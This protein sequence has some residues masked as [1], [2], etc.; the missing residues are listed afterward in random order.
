MQQSTLLKTIRWFLYALVGATPLVFFRYSLFP[1]GVPKIVFFEVFTELIVGGWIALLI[2]DWPNKRYLPRR[3]PLFW[4]IVCFTLL[5]LISAFHGPDLFRSFWSTLD[6]AFGIFG[7]L[8]VLA[9]MLIVPTLREGVPW[10]RLLTVSFVASVLTSL[11]VV[12]SKWGLQGFFL[13]QSIPRP[14]GTFGN[15]SFVGAYLLFNVFLGA[16]LWREARASARRIWIGVGVLVVTFGIL[17]TQ[18][19]GIILGL[20]GGAFVLLFWLGIESRGPARRTVLALVVIGV[21]VASLFVAT[22]KNSVWQKV[23]GLSRVATISRSQSDVQDRLLAWRAGWEGF[24]D[25]PLLGWGWENG[26][27]PFNTHYD[28]KLLVTSFEGTYFDKPHNVFLEQLETGGI[29]GFVSYL[30]LFVMWGYEL[31]RSRRGKF[32]S[33]VPF[34]GAGMVAYLL[35]NTIS[36]D[37]IGTYLMLA[38]FFAFVEH[39]YEEAVPRVSE[40]S[41]ADAHVSGAKQWASGV[42]LALTLCLALF[43][44]IPILTMSYNYYWG[45]N[46]FLNGLLESSSVSWQAALGAHTP[47]QDAVRKDYGSTLQQAFQQGLVYPHL[48]ALQAKAATEGEIAVSRH[49]DDYIYRISLADLYVTFTPFGQ[50]DYLT[51]AKDQIAAAMRLSPLRQQPYYVLARERI[52][53]HDNQGAV[54][55]LKKAIA[56]NPESGDPHFTYGL[57]A[58]SLG[59]AATGR[60]EVMTAAALG[61]TPVN[62]KEALALGGFKRD[63][64]HDYAE[65]VRYFEAAYD[66]AAFKGSKTQMIQA[67]IEA[68][69]L[70]ADKLG[71]YDEAESR[72]RQALL[73][74][75][76]NKINDQIP[77]VRL[78]LAVTCYLGRNTTCAKEEFQTLVAETNLKEL[79]IWQNLKPALDELGVKY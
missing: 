48:D 70:L 4:A 29:L 71:K 30:G 39:A 5:L 51:K 69:N 58:Y 2:V 57:L 68:A 13:N 20:V 27:I 62:A 61:R 76:D 26:N 78:K 3:T 53:E 32:A 63:S 60:F 65:A 23:P 12:F 45:I 22:R 38:V 73:V 56:L 24:K 36:F 49:P 55:A 74:A 44:A 35:E 47:Y 79:P 6:R 75:E 28:P 67:N 9:L 10:R 77:E 41:V 8:H 33:I 64:D 52:M 37:T 66:L 17:L 59:D 42:V 11:T 72:L 14:G 18:T 50:T 34:L 15:A 25:R 40:V 19:I 21:V 43:Y 1:F 54:D 46:Y 7:I 31:W 16:A